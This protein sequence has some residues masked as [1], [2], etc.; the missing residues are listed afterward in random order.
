MMSTLKERALFAIA[1]VVAFMLFALMTFAP[2]ML[3]GLSPQ[4]MVGIANGRPPP[5]L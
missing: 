3:H 2:G 5:V 4:D 1:A